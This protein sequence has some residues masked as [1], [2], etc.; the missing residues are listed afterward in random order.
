MTQISVLSTAGLERPSTIP[1]GGAPPDLRWLDIDA[2]YVDLSYQREVLRRGRRNIEKIASEFDWAFF[3]PVIVSPREGGDFFSI[4]D[5]QHRCAAAKLIGKTSVP[6]S[7]VVADVSKQAAAFRA[8]NANVT[9]MQPSHIHRAALRAGDPAAVELEE[10]ATDG[11]AKILA[12]PTSFDRMK[13]G[14]TQALATLR[15]CAGRYGREV[16]VR[17][18]LALT[19]S[20]RDYRGMLNE[21]MIQALCREIEPLPRMTREALSDIFEK[22][23]LKVVERAARVSHSANGGR[24]GDRLT[25]A[26]RKQLAPLV[27]RPAIQAPAPAAP[28][29]LPAPP[30]AV[31]SPRAD[32]PITTVAKGLSARA[33]VIDRRP[34]GGAIS[35]GEPAP[36]RS[37]LDQRRAGK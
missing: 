20:N 11:G 36:G 37:A 18:L 34:E 30:S 26:L 31:P 33:R 15:H 8:V 14:E 32:I 21:G 28:R 35:L 17:A 2:L 25:E 3:A 4:I 16:L 23:D 24:I 22:I 29:P 1:D 13:R 19:Q 6:C 27:A 10:I 9:K 5:G 12:S 7:I